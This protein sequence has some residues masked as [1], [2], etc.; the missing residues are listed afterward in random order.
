MSGAYRSTH[1][2]ASPSALATGGC[3]TPGNAPAPPAP[4][5]VR[6]VAPAPA[7]PPPPL[8]TAELNRLREEAKSRALWG[9]VFGVGEDAA[10][11]PRFTFDELAERLAASPPQAPPEEEEKK[12]GVQVDYQL[13]RRPV[14]P[15]MRVRH[16]L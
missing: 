13:R 9:Q 10:T 16:G 3:Y 1:S 5:V 6:Y 14:S 12:V 8:S 7:P 11:K 15:P 4:P 2:A